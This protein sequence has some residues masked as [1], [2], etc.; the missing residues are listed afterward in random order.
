[1]PQIVKNSP[2]LW[3]TWV[4]TLGLENPLE[5][6]MPTHSSI[7][8]WRH[9]MG[10]QSQT[11]WLSTQSPSTF[12]LQCSEDCST[13][14]CNSVLI[15][16]NILRRHQIHV[17]VWVRVFLNNMIS[18]WVWISPSLWFLCPHHI[19][20]QHQATHSPHS[21]NSFWCS[22]NGLLLFCASR[23]TP[24]GFTI[25]DFWVMRCPLRSRSS[26]HNYQK[27]AQE[28]KNWHKGNAR[29]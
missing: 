9:P 25:L 24:V 28:G 5:E 27:L 18:L 20:R 11:E 13:C 12:I 16:Y 8:A 19:A 3:E 26:D 4:Q 1:M 15:V 7:L 21:P 2:A 14:D 23:V 22:A 29:I 10:W 6:G 17:Y